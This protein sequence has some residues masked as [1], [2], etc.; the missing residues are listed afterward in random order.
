[1]PKEHVYMIFDTIYLQHSV[2]PVMQDGS[3]VVIQS[4]LPG[5]SST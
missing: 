5:G 3:H 4:V 2:T 1:M